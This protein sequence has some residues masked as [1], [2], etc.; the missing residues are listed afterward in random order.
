MVNEQPQQEQQVSPDQALGM[1]QEAFL[2][3]VK[4]HMVPQEALPI[5]KTIL[6][7]IQK[8]RGMMN[9]QQTQQGQAGQAGP[10]TPPE[11]QRNPVGSQ[12]GPM[13]GTGPNARRRTMI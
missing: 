4:K 10:Q 6:E 13:N 11:S 12:N 7:N 9:S 3:M 2:Q 1:I 5:I 8:L